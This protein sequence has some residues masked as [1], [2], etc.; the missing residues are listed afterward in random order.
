MYRYVHSALFLAFG[1]ITAYCQPNPKLE[2][3]LDIS[4]EAA[5]ERSML[6]MLAG[7]SEEE[8]KDLE[9]ALQIVFDDFGKH[10]DVELSFFGPDEEADARNLEKLQEYMK[11]LHGMTA[12]ELIDHAKTL[13][14]WISREELDELSLGFE[15][16]EYPGYL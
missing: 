7:V 11:P 10:V 14:N 3:T 1:V 13:P 6:A 8:A 12:H 4:S 2:P 16:L 9:H 5:L 15:Q